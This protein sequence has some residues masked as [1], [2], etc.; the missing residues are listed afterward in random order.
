LVTT[1]LEHNIKAVWFAFGNDLEK[2]VKFVRDYDENHNKTDKTL[3]FIQV[4]STQEARIA[5]EKWKIDVLVVQ[6]VD[7]APSS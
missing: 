2:W 3:V 7:I 1:A 4:N 6:G 5:V